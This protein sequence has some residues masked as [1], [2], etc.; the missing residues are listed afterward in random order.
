MLVR[1]VV[2]AAVLELA[3]LGN[4]VVLDNYLKAIV[5]EVLAQAVTVVAVA[6]QARLETLAAQAMATV[7]TVLQ[8][9]SLAHL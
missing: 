5:V 9:Q 3:P 7:A 8:T 4:L 6:V 1:L 2:Q